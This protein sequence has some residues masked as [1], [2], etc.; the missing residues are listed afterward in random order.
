MVGFR[1]LSSQ[2]AFD[3]G[4]DS[5]SRVRKEHWGEEVLMSVGLNL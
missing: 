1:G 4:R 2:I 5:S 3:R